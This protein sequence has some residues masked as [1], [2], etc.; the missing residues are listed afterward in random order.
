[1]RL[2]LIVTGL[3]GLLGTVQVVITL[4]LARSTK[5]R[6]HPPRRRAHRRA[7]GAQVE[8][9]IYWNALPW[10]SDQ[11][12]TGCTAV[13]SCSGQTI[14]H[15][16]PS[17]METLQ[18]EGGGLLPGGK[19]WITLVDRSS[20]VSAY[21]CYM[22]SNGPLSAQGTKL[23]PFVDVASNDHY[24]SSILKLEALVDVLMPDK[25]IKH[26]GCVRIV[27]NGYSRGE[28]WIDFYA[29]SRANYEFINQQLEKRGH[30]SSTG[31]IE[32]TEEDCPLLNYA[33]VYA[34]GGSTNAASYLA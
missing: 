21:G 9:T 34:P 8:L 28:N 33:P 12:S 6:L 27:D 29:L 17:Y 5:T 3:L 13:K 26:N 11:Q 31:I 32:T 24:Q 30:D 1:M 2:I 23:V 25:K 4:P 22:V 20:G 18:M 19:K 16:S 7:A 15:I 10:E 14:A